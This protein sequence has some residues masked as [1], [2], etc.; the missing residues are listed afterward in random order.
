MQYTLYTYTTKLHVRALMEERHA[1]H[2]IMQYTL[3]GV[4][5]DFTLTK[6]H[7]FLIIIIT[8]YFMCS[9]VLF[10]WRQTVRLHRTVEYSLC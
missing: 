4:C 6:G 2:T 10:V 7:N 1:V 9:S 5:L 8:L 3:S